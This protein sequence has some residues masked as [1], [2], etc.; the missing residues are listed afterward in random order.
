MA[1]L[2]DGGILKPYLD[3]TCPTKDYRLCAYKENLNTDPNH[4]LWEPGSPAQLEGGWKA[5]KPEYNRIV[6]DIHSHPKYLW[7]RV[8]NSAR[9]TV[10]QASVFGVGDGNWSFGEG[11][12]VHRAVQSYAPRDERAYLAARQHT[13]TGNA[14]EALRPVN[15]YLYIVVITSAVALTVMLLV[16]RRKFSPALRFF[17]LFTVAGIVLNLWNCATFAQVNGRYGCRV[18]WMIPFCALL[19]GAALVGRINRESRAERGF[20]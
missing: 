20:Q 8:Q 14:L 1:T 13:F 4:F 11:S 2:L 3:E 10:R 16:V 15:R 12:H 19:C 17:I 6:G 18:M 9:F 7:M 5:V